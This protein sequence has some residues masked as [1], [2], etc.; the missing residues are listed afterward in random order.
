[1]TLLIWKII[2]SILMGVGLG[3][4]LYFFIWGILWLI[5]KLFSLWFVEHKKYHQDIV[6][7][8]NYEM[9]LMEEINKLKAEVSHLQN[10][11]QWLEAKHKENK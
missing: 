4:C 2:F 1:M 7:Q 11:T 6:N 9:G 3:S 10:Q 5:R 8:L